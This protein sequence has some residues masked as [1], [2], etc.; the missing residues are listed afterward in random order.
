MRRSRL[1]LA[2]T[3]ALLLGLSLATAP[4]SAHGP[5]DDV[6]GGGA[7]GRE[8]GL[9]HISGHPPHG[10]GLGAHNPGTHQGFS[11]CLNVH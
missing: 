7:S 11:L 10:V 8:Y 3:L 5:C 9:F 2:A 4:V 6:D 1:A